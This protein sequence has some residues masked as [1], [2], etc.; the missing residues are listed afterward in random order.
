MNG[1]DVMSTQQLEIVLVSISEQR[2]IYHVP[3][4]ALKLSV[5]DVCFEAKLHLLLS[6]RGTAIHA[7]LLCT[8]L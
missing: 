6:M 2:G 7:N 4:T 3:D 5:H 1:I 8:S